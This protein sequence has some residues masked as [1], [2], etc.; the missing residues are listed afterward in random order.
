MGPKSTNEELR[1]PLE[2]R[3]DRVG[4]VARVGVVSIDPLRVVGLKAIF[5][6]V[7]GIE[8][9]PLSIPGAL[10]D[11]E[12]SLVIVDSGCTTHLFELIGA[13]RKARPKLKLV[14]LGT[15]TAPEYIERVIGAGA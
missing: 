7:R 5:A 6:D 14:V 11:A 10:D 8:I 15:E 1:T 12:L 13:F 3:P 2:Q 4:V 9:V